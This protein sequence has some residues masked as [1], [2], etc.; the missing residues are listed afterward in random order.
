MHG[1]VGTPGGVTLVLFLFALFV[2]ANGNGNLAVALDAREKGLVCIPVLQ[3]TKVPAV[4]WKRWQTEMPPEWWFRKWF[5]GTTMNVAIITTGM[6]LF[7]CENQ[8]TAEVVLAHCG[9]TP[10]KVKTPG[11]GV[12]LGFR[13]RAGA[14]LRNQVKVKG[15]NFDIRTDGGLELIPPSKTAKGR[16]EWLGEGLHAVSELPVARIEW[17][18]PRAR[19]KAAV[20]NVSVATAD[21]NWLFYRG[22]RYVD[23]FERAVS[24]EG[25]HRSTFIATWKIVRF[26]NFDGYLAWRLLLYFNA[27]KCDPPWREEPELRHKLEDAMRLGR[28]S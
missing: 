9:A 22:Q 24:G 16:Y 3:G 25:G 26:A 14:T 11:G 21:S 2:M 17:T 6:V 10:H 15:M 23:R 13:R 5:E 20:P 19:N 7:D 28:R 12:H 27:T 18:R 1:G 8:A 4:R